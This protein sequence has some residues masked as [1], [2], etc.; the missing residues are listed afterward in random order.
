L[1]DRRTIVAGAGYEE[2][3]RV[4]E[5]LRAPK[6]AVELAIAYAIRRPAASVTGGWAALPWPATLVVA[7]A[8][9]AWSV[10]RASAGLADAMRIGVRVRGAPVL[11]PATDILAAP[12]DLVP[13]CTLVSDTH[14][15][16]GDRAPV[17]LELDPRQWPRRALPTPGEIGGRLRRVLEHV[18]RDGPRTVIWCG[19]EVDRGDPAEWA[20]WRDAIDA[21]P[22]LVHR[23]IPGNHDICFN[24]PYDDDP[25]LARRAIRERAF[26]SHGPRLAD[27][28]EVD[29]IASDAGPVHVI[30]LDSCK[31]PSK[32]ILSNAIGRFGDIQIDEVERILASR[33]GPLLCIA[34]HHVWR[35]RRFLHIDEWYNT[36]V[37]ADRL[38][39]VLLAYRRRD[40]RNRVLVCHGHRHVLTTGRIVDGDASIDVVGLP[41]TTLGGKSRDGVLDTVTRYGIAGLRRDGSWTI[42]L[43]DVTAPG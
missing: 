24:A 39:S 19:D 8:A 29:T 43:I 42:A 32:H 11:E 17:E 15:T 41:S 33:H 30:L 2:V 5:R 37:D 3:V 1:P 27:F 4:V 21:V 34:H 36:A 20:N 16:A 7:P 9:V 13:V 23:L 31:H 18:L 38:A 26:Q 28:P 35:S 40:P 22:G 25:S 6:A 12:S 14:V 10:M